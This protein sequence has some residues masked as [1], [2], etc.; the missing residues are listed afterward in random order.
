M[1]SMNINIDPGWP[2]HS[3]KDTMAGYVTFRN[4]CHGIH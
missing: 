3:K 4:A 2:D 1:E